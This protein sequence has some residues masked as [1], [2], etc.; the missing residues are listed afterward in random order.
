MQQ[1]TISFIILSL[2]ILFSVPAISAEEIRKNPEHIVVCVSPEDCIIDRYCDNDDCWERRSD[3]NTSEEPQGQFLK[4]I[5]SA[6]PE[7]L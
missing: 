3:K 1:A 6:I 5:Q 7:P 4:K 2:S